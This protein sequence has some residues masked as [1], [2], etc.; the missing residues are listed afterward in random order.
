[1]DRRSFISLGLSA[2]AVSAFGDPVPEVDP[3]TVSVKE[4]EDAIRLLNATTWR[5]AAKREMALTVAQNHIYAM[6]TGK[7]YI[8][9]VTAGLKLS[10]SEVADW[11]AKHPVL[12]WYD[13]AF[14]KVLAEV[15]ATEVKGK[16]PAV[17]YVYNMGFVVKTATCAFA[18][19]LCHRKAPELVP[20]LDFALCSHN[21]GDHYTTAFAGAMSKANKPFI[22]NFL[23]NYDAY[24]KAPVKE[25][26]LKGVTLRITE[27]DHNPHLPGSI[28]CVEA[29]CSQD[30]DAYVIYHSGDAHRPDQL[31]P[32]CP[33]P[34]L[35]IGHTAIG[36]SFPK[37]YE[38]TMSA[39]VMVTAHHQELGH[40]GGRW[41]CVGFH[42]EPAKIAKELSALGATAAMPVWGE[43]MV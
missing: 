30:P 20:Y 2:A 12:K 43:R 15:K 16:T 28:N 27:A 37:A 24:V 17:W 5:D 4:L 26:T 41:R 29:R 11:H 22:T 14:D 23:L 33:H 31:H 25:M 1:M 34:D 32:V 35:F 40:L 10:A 19:D 6:K 18:L 9:F 13:D 38:T 8:D 36:F 42:E 3:S 7:P 21:H 39:K